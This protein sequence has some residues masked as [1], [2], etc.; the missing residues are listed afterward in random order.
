VIVTATNRTALVATLP[1]KPPLV[2]VLPSHEAE[3]CA[4]RL[5][6]LG[7]AQVTPVFCDTA[8]EA[9]QELDPQPES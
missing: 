5:T 1:G 9:L 2:V 3:A 4:A 6:E 7:V 8:S